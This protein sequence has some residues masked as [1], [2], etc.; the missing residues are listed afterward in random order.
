MADAAKPAA[1]SMLSPSKA[2]LSASASAASVG[3]LT[4][5]ASANDGGGDAM[6]RSVSDFELFADR[7]GSRDRYRH[8]N[9]TQMDLSQ[10]K[11]G[12][13]GH[14]HDAVVEMP[15]LRGAS[16][17]GLLQI[18]GPA[19]PFRAVQEE[20]PDYQR[21]QRGRRYDMEH[22]KNEHVH[23]WAASKFVSWTHSHLYGAQSM[24]LR[25]HCIVQDWQG[26][27]LHRATSPEHQTEAAR[28][29]VFR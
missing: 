23:R 25:K 18:P 4:L 1:H 15:S 24:R 17:G 12:D 28:P 8:K 14:G 13:D 2:S 19:P 9:G 27:S 10:F 7:T 5:E 26:I 3:L 29:F 20:L 6:R 21:T 11:F 16:R 22:G